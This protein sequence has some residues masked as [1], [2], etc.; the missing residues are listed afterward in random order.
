MQVHVQSGGEFI[1]GLQIHSLYISW[2]K[3]RNSKKNL[4]ETSVFEK[5]IV[6]RVSFVV[7][8]HITTLY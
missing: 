8:Q 6:P 3:A 1:I 7:V 5:D 4:W 2:W